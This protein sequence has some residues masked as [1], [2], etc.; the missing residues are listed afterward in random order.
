MQQ[1][2]TIFARPPPTSAFC[3]TPDIID[4]A[5]VGPES[6]EIFK[7]LEQ[8]MIRYAMQVGNEIARDRSRVAELN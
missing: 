1:R 7:E 3:G 8:A 2:R 6:A 5:A 4:P